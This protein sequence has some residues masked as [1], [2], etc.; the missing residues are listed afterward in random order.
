MHRISKKGISTYEQKKTQKDK[1]AQLRARFEP[2]TSQSYSICSIAVLQQ[3]PKGTV[4]KFSDIFLEFLLF[5]HTTKSLPSTS[6]KRF[7]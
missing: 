4:V 1:K 3:L 5:L 7:A 2:R 6:L